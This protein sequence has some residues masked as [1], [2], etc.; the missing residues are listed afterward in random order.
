MYSF[1]GLGIRDI[2]AIIKRS[3][4]ALNQF[5]NIVLHYGTNDVNLSSNSIQSAFQLLTEMTES[6]DHRFINIPSLLDPSVPILDGRTQFISLS[7]AYF[8]DDSIDVG[9]LSFS[10][11][12]P[13]DHLHY[14]RITAKL[15]IDVLTSHL[16]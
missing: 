2:P 5:D 10:R 7:K 14:S 6:L 8:G 12:R 13:N 1:S 9:R 4:N 3:T 15:I 11:L 16:N